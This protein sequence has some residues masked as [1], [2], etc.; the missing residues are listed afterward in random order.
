MGQMCT[1]S[2]M[3]FLPLNAFS[4]SPLPGRLI[5]IKGVNCSN[6]IN[7]VYMMMCPCGKP[8]V[9]KSRLLKKTGHVFK[10]NL[11]LYLFHFFY[12]PS[13]RR[14][15]LNSLMWY[16]RNTVVEILPLKCIGFLFI[17]LDICVYLH[18]NNTFNYTQSATNEIILGWRK[19]NVRTMAVSSWQRILTK[20][21]MDI[22]LY[23]DCV[24]RPHQQ[25]QSVSIWWSGNEVLVSSS[26]NLTSS[27][28]L[29]HL[30]VIKYSE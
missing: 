29:F 10:Q 18:L 21:D 9:S 14:S 13:S 15:L 5:K 2:S 1:L 17:L 24:I 19:F 6:L 26:Q 4:H 25:T 20:S 7:L 16:S 22:W 30:R 23:T 3:W 27:R 8:Y 28:H 11:H 12:E